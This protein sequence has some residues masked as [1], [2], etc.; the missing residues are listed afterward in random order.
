VRGTPLDVFG[1]AAVRRVERELVE[2]Y[3]QMLRAAC[4]RLSRENHADAVA[5]AELPDMVRGYEQI[6]LENVRRYREAA[7]GLM[8]KLGIE[9][10]QVLQA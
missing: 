6:K 1:Y 7:R 10:G 5:L 3:R 8:A 2:E 4:A 9:S